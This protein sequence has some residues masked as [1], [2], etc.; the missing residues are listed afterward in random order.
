MI[1]RK[2]VKC[3]VFKFR[4]AYQYPH[5]KTIYTDCIY[6]KIHKKS[7]RQIPEKGFALIEE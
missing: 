7:K 2:V 3:D 4:T 5:P 1:Y 6:R